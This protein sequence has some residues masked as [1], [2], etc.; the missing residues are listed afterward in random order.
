MRRH[1]KKDKH[2]PKNRVYSARTLD[3]ILDEMAIKW[4]LKAERSHRKGLALKK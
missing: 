1:L 3:E 2:G 4:A